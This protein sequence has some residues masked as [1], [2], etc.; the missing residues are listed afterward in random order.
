MRSWAYH[1]VLGEQRRLYGI[2]RR[3]FGI[4]APLF[5]AVNEEVAEQLIRNGFKNMGLMGITALDA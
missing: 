5:A 2:A 1:P 4:S 3:A